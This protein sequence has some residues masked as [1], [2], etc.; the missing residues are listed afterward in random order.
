MGVG[1]EVFGLG[2]AG[3]TIL[4]RG[5]FR[6]TRYLRQSDIR[7]QTPTLTRTKPT[8]GMEGFAIGI[9]TSPSGRLVD[10]EAGDSGGPW[11]VNTDDHPENLIFGVL[12]AGFD[13]GT[14][15]IACFE[16]SAWARHWFSWLG[17]P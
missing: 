16:E 11:F 10:T 8:E 4:K 13:D 3:S 2:Y 12:S 1:S 9:G 14:A 7:P 5:K 15:S 6:V 17:L